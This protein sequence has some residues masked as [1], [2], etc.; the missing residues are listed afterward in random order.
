MVNITR[1]ATSETTRALANE[2]AQN[3][4]PALALLGRLVKSINQDMLMA[5]GLDSAGAIDIAQLAAAAHRAMSKEDLTTPEQDHAVGLMVEVF[6]ILES[7]GLPLA[8]TSVRSVPVCLFED[9]ESQP[10]ELAKICNKYADHDGLDYQLCATFLKEVEAIGY[11]FEYGLDGI[12][13][14]LR[15]IGTEIAD[16]E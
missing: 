14:D 5:G 4:Q 16:T 8:V 13:F 6:S 11:T 9:H 10:P 3:H 1:E 12:P 7:K 2:L 15:P